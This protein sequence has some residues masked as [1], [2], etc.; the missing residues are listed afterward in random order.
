MR[1][2]W[3]DTSGCIQSKEPRCGCSED[4]ETWLQRPFRGAT[5]WFCR[6]K[7]P[8]AVQLRVLHRERRNAPVG[9]EFFYFW[10]G[11]RR[12][13][14]SSQRSKPTNDSF[15]S[16]TDRQKNRMVFP[17][18]DFGKTYYVKRRCHKP[19]VKKYKKHEYLTGQELKVCPTVAKYH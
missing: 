8:P 16:W 18:L 2:R 11:I 6:L 17:A 4:E 14:S 7:F 10:S 3:S 12:S 13:S 1:R 15:V 9:K 5:V 19:L